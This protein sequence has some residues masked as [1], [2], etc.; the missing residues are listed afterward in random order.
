MLFKA[1]KKYRKSFIKLILLLLLSN[2]KK[3]LKTLYFKAFL[4]SIS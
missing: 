1:A 2:I 3:A 4:A